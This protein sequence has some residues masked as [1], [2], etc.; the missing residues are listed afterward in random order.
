MRGF[1]KKLYVSQDVDCEYAVEFENLLGI[2]QNC[3]EIEKAE[4]K[5]IV[6][7]SKKSSPKILYTQQ[8]IDCEYDVEFDDLLDL[9]EGFDK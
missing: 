9:I 8:E 5:G 3:S 2:I 7:N 1:R 4:I 6:T